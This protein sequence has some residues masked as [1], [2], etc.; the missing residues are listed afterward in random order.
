MTLA[1]TRLISMHQNKGKSLRA[2]LGERT[3][4]AKNP[5]K[6]Q[7]GELVTAYQCTPETV[8]TDFMLTK[9]EYEFQTGRTQGSNVIAYQIRQSFKPGEVTPE[10][11]NQIGYDLA[12][13]FTKGNH[14]FI[15]CTHTDK[16]HI[17]NHIIFNSTNLDG[18]KKFKDFYLS[19]KAVRKISDR[20]C[21]ENGLSIVEYPKT[22]GDHYGAWLGDKKPQSLRAD[23]EK[24]ID[25][26]LA[27]QPQSLEE[28]LQEMSKAGFQIKHG[29]HL[30]FRRPDRE[31][32]I[33]L[34]SLSEE[35]SEENIL[36][37]IANPTY[38][39][40]T[41]TQG[42]PGSLLI[43]IDAKLQEG[44]GRGYEQWAKEFN[45][46]Q[47]AKSLSYLS[48]NNLLHYGTL[49][50]KAAN[51]TQEF[52]Q[53][54][55]EIQALETKMAQVS[56]LQKHIIQ[57]NKTREV[58]AD[59]KQ[60][61]YSPQYLAEHREDIE[62]HREAKAFFDQEGLKLLPTVWA[63]KEEYQ[64]LAQEK[65]ALYGAYREAKKEMKNVSI[66][67]ANIDCLLEKTPPK[68]EQKRSQFER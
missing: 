1:T 36:A 34:R 45:L 33:R 59:Y 16:A 25:Q 50:E 37:K 41:K 64:S 48:D 21:L 29:K 18:T 40:P 26:V 63:L 55:A 43:D 35:Y 3:D 2:C 51:A 60:G 67:K 6:T 28:F 53:M 39:V 31:R 12:M 20:L 24:T 23:L 7:G 52:D 42:Q 30:A 61:G 38:E 44:K 65:N 54:Q 56:K 49:E 27:K 9:K 10:D 66:A 11:A 14:A 22:K 58:F 13:K 68:K 62:I 47:A 8:D 57:Y 5:E 46:K 4:Y 15:V 32:F 19:Q 17:H